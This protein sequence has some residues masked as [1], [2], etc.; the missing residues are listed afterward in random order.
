[1]KRA[2]LRAACAAAFVA[3]FGLCVG[4]PAGTAAQSGSRS[5]PSLQFITPAQAQMPAEPAQVTCGPG[6]YR[7]GNL[8]K[9][10]TCCNDQDHC[11]Y[12]RPEIG[13]CYCVAPGD[14]CDRY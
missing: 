10:G 7:C 1:M 12:V 9:N 4:I 5:A 3:F 13:S 6:G 8:D 2:V 14:K 11:C